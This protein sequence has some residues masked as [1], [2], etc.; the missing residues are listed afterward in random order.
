MTRGW[1]KGWQARGTEHVPD[2][3][4]SEAGQGRARAYDHPPAP[5]RGRTW[6]ASPSPVPAAV[7]GGEGRLRRTPLTGGVVL[8]AVSSDGRLTGNSAW[9]QPC[10]NGCGRGWE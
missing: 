2:G 10:Q 5:L 3:V 4:G 6:L 7:H 9:H 1:G 8:A